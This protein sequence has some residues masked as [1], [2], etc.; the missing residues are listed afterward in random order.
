VGGI[1]VK[2][3]KNRFFE[4]NPAARQTFLLAIVAVMGALIGLVSPFIPMK[5]AFIV[6]GGIALFILIYRNLYLGIILFLIFNLTLPQAGPGLDIGLKA[7]VV[8]ERGIHFNM[9]EIFMAMVLVAWLIQVFIKKADWKTK[10]PLIIPIILYVLTSIL[11][12]FVG[13]LHG[14]IPG[15]VIFRFIRTVFFCYIFFLVLNLIK[16]RKQFQQ[17]ILIMLICATL[18]ASFGLMQKVLGQ[19]WSEMVAEKVFDKVLGYPKDVNYVAGAGPTQVYRINSTFLHPNIL[20]GYL[21]FFLPFFVSLLWFFR[22]WWMR[23]LLIIGLGINLTALFY[24]GSRA[25][26]IAAGVIVLIYGALG[27]LDRRIVLVAATAIMIIVL[28]VVIIKPPEFLRQRFVSQSAKLATTGRLMQYKL[29][30]DFFF[31]HPILGLGMGMEGQRIVEQNIRRQW[32]AVENVYLTYLVSH[33][34]VGLAAYLLLFIVY[35]IILL[36][37]RNNSQYDP[38]LRFNSEAFLLGM[39]GFAVANLFGAWLLFAVPMITLYWFF[40]GMGGTIYNIFREGR[41]D[42]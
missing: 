19:S 22:R 9:H 8:G 6:I 27:L 37:V 5:I 21:V 41:E 11:A 42:W 29:A 38:F 13:L 2:P 12:C 26:W 33:G 36:W 1:K 15:L 4:S 31:E 14:A 32:A 25:S 18:V 23:L 17:L 7:P 28:I 34:L 20:G 39:V 16:T 3:V 30:L 10:S 35:W 24:T 40:M